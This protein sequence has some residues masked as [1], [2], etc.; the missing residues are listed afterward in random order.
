MAITAFIGYGVA[1]RQLS[2]CLVAEECLTK[3]DSIKEVSDL[4]RAVDSVYRFNCL[5]KCL[6]NI[7][8]LCSN[9]IYSICPKAQFVKS[10]FP[11][12]KSRRTAGSV[13]ILPHHPS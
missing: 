4:L 9:Y 6:H 10:F 5:F 7:S 1:H 12:K 13:A 3:P 8:L 11:S 2:D